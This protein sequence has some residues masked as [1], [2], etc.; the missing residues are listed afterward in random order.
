MR[1]CV[2]AD[3]KHPGEDACLVASK[4]PGEDACFTGSKHP[5]EDAWL[6]DRV[7]RTLRVFHSV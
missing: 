5:G 1:M 4:H 3:S 7:N 2:L 6:A